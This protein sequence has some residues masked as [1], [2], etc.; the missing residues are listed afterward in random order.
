MRWEDEG[1]ASGVEHAGLGVESLAKKLGADEGMVATPGG[2]DAVNMQAIGGDEAAN[3]IGGEVEEALDAI[4]FFSLP[5]STALALEECFGGP[6][7]APED[8]GGVGAGGHGVEILVELDGIDLL[9]FIHGEEQVGGGAHD[10]GMGLPGEELE[11]GT[12]KGV[13]VALGGM[14]AAA[15]TDTLIQ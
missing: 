8:A 5:G 12:A 11:A 14:P 15:R 7:G 9:G 4:Q 6:G 1:E 13:H 10:P 2:D 3:V